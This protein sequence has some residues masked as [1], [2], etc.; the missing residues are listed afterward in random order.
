M[1]LT[2]ETSQE[3]TTLAQSMISQGVNTKSYRNFGTLVRMNS[4]DF[5]NFEREVAL[6]EIT[7]GN[8]KFVFYGN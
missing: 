6:G 2:E 3:L 7:E 4:D 8:E 5:K 1:S